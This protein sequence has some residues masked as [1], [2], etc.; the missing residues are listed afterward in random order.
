MK[1]GNSQVSMTSSGSYR[2]VYGKKTTK[3]KAIERK[4]YNG[5]GMQTVRSFSELKMMLL[6]K[7]MQA[8]HGKRAACS[9]NLNFSFS[10][11]TFVIASGKYVVQTVES[12]FYEEQEAISFNSEGKVVTED[13]REIVFDIS[14][15]MTRKFEQRTRNYSP[16]EMFLCDPLVINFDGDVAELGN[17]KFLFDL[18]ADGRQEEISLFS[19]NSGFLALDRN[20][21]GIINDGTELF[22]TASG[23]GFADLAKYDSDGNGWIDE[24]DDV[25]DKLKVWKKDSDGKDVL[26]SLKAA[27]VG[28]LYLGNVATPFSLNNPYDNSVN[29]VIRESSI[30]LGE[31]GGAGTVQHVDFAV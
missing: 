12:S 1:I 27:G 3:D 16:G 21:D 8:I 17:E 9:N 5:Q 25:F 23:D 14:F 15:E 10:G 19:S 29:G 20:G 13:G 18:D 11:R 26:T 4:S 28:A 6:D 24:N 31:N 2:A 7:M 22:G 30:Y